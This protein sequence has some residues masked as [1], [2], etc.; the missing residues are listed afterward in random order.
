M[1]VQITTE[2]NVPFPPR[3]KKSH[4][5]KIYIYDRSRGCRTCCNLIF[6]SIK[7]IFHSLCTIEIGIFSSLSLAPLSNYILRFLAFFTNRTMNSKCFCGFF[8]YFFRLLHNCTFSYDE[9]QKC[10]FR[11]REMV[12]W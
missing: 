2:K 12:G 6:P 8:S 7:H 3:E 10:F 9:E 5:L 4:P 1:T 11:E